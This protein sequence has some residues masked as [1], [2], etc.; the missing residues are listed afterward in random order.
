MKGHS[1]RFS[2]DPVGSLRYPVRV[3][4]T[5]ALTNHPVSSHLFLL[6]SGLQ[7]VLH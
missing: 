1:V 4:N 7:W 6:T 2:S 3:I 5:Y